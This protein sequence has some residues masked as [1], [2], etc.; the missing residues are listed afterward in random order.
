MTTEKKKNK[1][2]KT[3]FLNII[4]ISLLFKCLS[5]NKHLKRGG[6]SIDDLTTSVKTFYLIGLIIA[7]I[8]LIQKQYIGFFMIILGLWLWS[9]LTNGDFRSNSDAAYYTSMTLYSLTPGVF[10]SFLQQCCNYLISPKKNM[11]EY[12]SSVYS[13]Y[14]D[15]DDDYHDPFINGSGPFKSPF[16]DP[17]PSPFKDPFEN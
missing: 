4:V 3:I 15:D 14:D 6:L 5:I 17:F 8:I 13:D 2:G 1:I 12:N 7:I 10:V 11:T 9:P 16:K